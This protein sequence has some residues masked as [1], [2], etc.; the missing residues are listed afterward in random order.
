MP[1]LRMR[2]EQAGI[3][4]IDERFDSRTARRT[5]DAKLVAHARQQFIDRELWIEQ[6]SDVASGRNLFEQAAADGGFAGA[7]FACEQDEAAVAAYPIEQMGE[8]L[9]VTFAHIQ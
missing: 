1:A 3:Y 5:L 2:I 7:N 8:R 9:L 6:I 4:A